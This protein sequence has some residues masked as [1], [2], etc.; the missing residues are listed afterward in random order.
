MSHPKHPTVPIQS[1][2]GEIIP[3]DV[4]IADLIA[5]LWDLGFRTTNS[6]QDNYV[7]ISGEKAHWVW[8]E[9]AFTKDAHRFVRMFIDQD[10]RRLAHVEGIWS[11]NTNVANDNVTYKELSDDE[12]EVIDELPLQLRFPTSVRFPREQLSDVKKA[13]L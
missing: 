7:N 12:V 4:K 8:I 9:F 2:S 3:V 5:K 1:P 6:C 10:I 11:I 13:F